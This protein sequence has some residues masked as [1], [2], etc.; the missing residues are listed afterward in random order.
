V[1]EAK[2]SADDRNAGSGERADGGGDGVDRFSAGC[3]K[4]ENF[5]E[6]DIQSHASCVLSMTRHGCVEDSWLRI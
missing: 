1:P 5:L 4:G 2:I 3:G 6:R